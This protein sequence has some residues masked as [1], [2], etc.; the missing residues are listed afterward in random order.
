[1]KLVGITELLQNARRD[2]YAVGAFN[3]CNTETMQAVIE[4][5]AE[6]RSPVMLIASPFDASIVG[7]KMIAETAKILA[8]EVDVPVC[9]HL[10]H[11]HTLDEI[12]ECIE[13]GWP[14]VMIDASQQSFEDNVRLTKAVVEM[15]HAAGI[16]VEGELGAVGRVDDITVEGMRESTLTDPDMAAQFVKL[17]GVDAL[18]VSI[19]NAHGMYPQRPEL[20]FDILAAVAS[21]VDVPLVL[22][23]GSGTPPEQLRKAVQ[24]GISKVNVASE[25]CRAYMD[26]FKQSVDDSDGKIWWVGAMLAAKAAI[27][28]VVARWMKELGS[29]GRI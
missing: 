12:K 9:L 8:A 5:G 22:H 4:T 24:G 15:A 21:A 25:L 20:D 7:P 13:A 3:H 11:A 27:K 2:H 14:S 28:P 16:P 1:M 6:L 17:T 19:G 26:A 18:A 23:G 10:D 29:A